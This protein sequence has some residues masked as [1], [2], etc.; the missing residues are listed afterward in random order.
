M[1]LSMGKIHVQTEIMK[2]VQG[3]S[4]ISHPKSVSH[5]SFLF[6]EMGSIIPLPSRKGLEITC[7][8]MLM[9]L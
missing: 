3:L 5:L 1:K 9:L 8:S 6:C 4:W 2:S 7:V